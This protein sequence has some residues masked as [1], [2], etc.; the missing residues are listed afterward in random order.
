[1]SEPMDID[2]SGIEHK[3]SLSD[4]AALEAYEQGI[5]A[6]VLGKAKDQN[7]YSAGSKLHDEWE[8]GWKHARYGL[9]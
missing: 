5:A 4:P 2:L 7:F 1:M 3:F 6:Y 8:R 9:V